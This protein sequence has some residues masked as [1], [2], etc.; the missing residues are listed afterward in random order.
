MPYINKNSTWIVNRFD[1]PDIRI[2][3]DTLVDDLYKEIQKQGIASMDPATFKSYLFAEESKIKAAELKKLEMIEDPPV[4]G[5]RLSLGD[6]SSDEAKPK[7][8]S[9]KKLS[10]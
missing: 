1:A 9:K 4:L 3:L 2:P 6:V 7:K 8:K 10:N 5:V